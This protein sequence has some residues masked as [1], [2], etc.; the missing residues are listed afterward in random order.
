MIP[1]SCSILLVTKDKHKKNQIETHLLKSRVCRWNIDWIDNFQGAL[2]VSNYKKY[3]SFIVDCSLDQLTTLI[4]QIQ[5]IPIIFITQKITDGIKALE[6]GVE[7]YW[8]EDQLKSSL[9]ENS[10]RLVINHSLTKNSL[11]ECR[12]YHK[13]FNYQYFEQQRTETETLLNTVFEQIPTGCLILDKDGLI[14]FANTKAT[15][16]F[17]K[18]LHQLIGQN[19]GIPVGEENSIELEILQSNRSFKNVEIYVSNTQWN[20]EDAYLIIMAD[21]TERKQNELH[22]KQKEKQYRTLVNNLPGAV[23]RCHY[24]ETWKTIYVSHEIENILGYSPD[25]FSGENQASLCDFIH[26]EDKQKVYQL[27]DESLNKKHCFSIEYRAIDHQGNVKWLWEK[28]QG[29]FDQKGNVLWLDGVIFDITERKEIEEALIA[30]EEKFRL[31]TEN[32][33]EIFFIYSGDNQKAEYVS[34]AYE[35]IFEQTCESLYKDPTNWLKKVHPDD[36]KMITD[37]GE[38]LLETLNSNHREYRIIRN[39]GEIRWISLNT[40]F[41]EDAQGKAQ[42][43]VGVAE[44]ITTRKIVETE[45]RESE[46]RYRYLYENTPVILHSINHQGYLLNMSNKWLETFG[47]SKEEVIG[48][49]SIDFLTEKSREYME[50]T[51]LPLFMK[52]GDCENIECEFV[53]KD[54]SI[55]NIL[56]SAT[57]EKDEQGNFQRSLAVLEDVTERKILEK[58]IKN[59]QENLEKLVEERTKSLRESEAKN[60]ALLNAIPDLMFRIS[61]EGIYLDFHAQNLEDLYIN[62]E[63]FLGNNFKDHLPPELVEKAIYAHEKAFVNG[64]V[65][66]FEYELIIQGEKRYYENRVVANGKNEVLAIIR[67]ITQQTKALQERE[68][69]EKQLQESEALYRVLFSMIADAIFLTDEKGNFTFICDNVY[70]I[71]G[72]TLE[73]VAAMGTIY[74]LIGATESDVNPLNFQS[75]ITNFEMEIINKNNQIHT[76]LIN[77]KLV[78]IKQGK[79]LITCHDI[80]DH[81]KAELALKESETRFRE[82]VEHIEESFWVNSPDPTKVIYIS[83]GYEKIWGRSCESLLADGDSWI[84]SVHPEDRTQQIEALKRMAQGEEYNEEYRIIRPDGEIRWVFARSYKIYDDQGNLSRHVGIAEDITQRKETEEKLLMAHKIAGLGNWDWN[85]LTNEI[86]WSQEIYTIFGRG[87][88]E[89]KPTY[90]NLLICVHPDDRQLVK[91]MLN[92]A[93]ET[94]LPYSLDHRIILPDG[95]IKIVHEQGDV[96]YNLENKPIHMIGT[97]QDI[98]ER[99]K[100]EQALR[101]SETRLEEAQKVA[102]IGSWEYDVKT[103]KME[104]SKELFNLYEFD[105]N[106]PPPSFDRHLKRIHPE[107]QIKAK[108]LFEKAINEGIPYQFDYRIVIPNGT[109][110]YA[111]A[112]GKPIFDRYGKVIKVFGTALDITQRKKTEFA[113]KES[114]ERFRVIFE[115][116]GIGMSICNLGGQ[117]LQ[118]NPTLSKIVGYSIPELLERNIH[119]ITVTKYRAIQKNKLRQLILGRIDNVSLE[120]YYICKDGSIC[121]VNAIISLMTDTQGNPKNLIYIVEDITDRKQAKDELEKAKEKA[122]SA[123]LAKSNFLAN[124]SHELRTPLNA[125]L[126]FTQLISRANNL[127]KIHYEH[128]QIINRSGEYLLSLINDILDI[129]KIEAGQLET[130]QESFNL[131]N[132]L[133]DLNQ[134]FSLKAF[135]KHLKLNIKKHSPIPQYIKCDQKKL[136]SVLINLLGNGIKFTEKGEITLKIN[137]EEISTQDNS[138][139]LDITETSQNLIKYRLIFEVEDTGMGIAPEEIDSLFNLFVQSQSGKQQ[140]EGTGLGL[141]ISKRF[142]AMMGG[143]INVQSTLGVGSIFTFDILCESAYAE[144]V[145]I[146]PPQ[147]HIIGLNLEPNQPPPTILVIEDKWTN[148][149]LLLSILQPLGFRVETAENG[150]IGLQMWENIHPDLILMDI[151]MPVMDGYEATKEIRRREKSQQIQGENCISVIPIIALTASVFNS[152]RETLLEIGCNDFIPKPLNENQLLEKIG[153]YLDINYVYQEIKPD[154]MNYNP[155]NLEQLTITSQDLGIMSQEWREELKTSALSARASRIELLID[156]IPSNYEHIKKILKDL[157]HHLDYD[158]IADLAKT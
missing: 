54:G 154:I 146:K 118:V 24:K 157:L 14:H 43:I 78:N 94:H 137:S 9:L 66:T 35:T 115:Q 140:A 139:T 153:L 58:Q 21:I 130:D 41:I 106:A 4:D 93:I 138:Q 39:N 15:Q 148:C 127:A 10:L 90:T 86:S 79:A 114:E 104:W 3:H 132:L 97:V 55:V 81:K 126:G 89:F 6:R 91:D 8:L 36:L 56:L 40:F 63:D 113:L 88:E 30:S 123:N 151:R 92:Q 135:S 147:Y 61:K 149:E 152:Q 52:L 77:V 129:S 42:Q 26:P 96:L 29:I 87:K 44:D 120:K 12:A 73:E 46:K 20:G 108:P 155:I 110:R 53:K 75:E 142:I 95:K 74:N 11:E 101:E 51:H 80:S 57:S 16:I 122:E 17:D 83:P 48:K 112:R 111:E 60:K 71:F 121:W 76:I 32:I 18:P 136:R 59:Y 67:D 141:A 102:H 107:D 134:M 144:D 27:M 68:K 131:Y 99:K 5:S 47:Y 158:K 125:I 143:T 13:A 28:G 69:A 45:L 34:P 82:L 65:E 100:V 22:L 31:I 119:D 49:K 150:E 64:M 133:D 116:A 62:P 128:L 23:Y 7:D 50:K 38:K 124:M 145:P 156:Q 109:I 1:K 72:Y 98:T 103:G 117:F 70:Y 19:F 25:Y 33:Q 84:D 85:I 2:V 105:P 37:Q